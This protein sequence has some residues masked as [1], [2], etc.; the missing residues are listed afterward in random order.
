MPAHVAASSTD[1]GYGLLGHSLSLWCGVCGLLPDVVE[2][3]ILDRAWV[4]GVASAGVLVILDCWHLVAND[5]LEVQV[6]RSLAG[7]SAWDYFIQLLFFGCC[8]IFWHLRMK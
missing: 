7:H 8:T 5:V 2:L 1:S 6:L 3:C 4:A